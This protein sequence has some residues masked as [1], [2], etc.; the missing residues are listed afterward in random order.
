MDQQCTNSPVLIA[1]ASCAVMMLL[2]VLIISYHISNTRTSKSKKFPPMAPGGL[3]ETINI[4][5]SNNCPWWLL[6][7]AK[8]LDSSIFRMNLYLPRIPMVLQVGDPS[9]AKEIMI[10]PLT[11][12]PSTYSVFDSV[13]MGKASIF[14]SNGKYWHDRRKG[15][16]PAFSSR[17]VKRM[18]AVALKKVD[19]WI[20]T[21][22]TKMVE[23]GQ[24]FDVGKEMIGITLDSIIQ[25]AFEYTM[26][27]DEKILYFHELDLCLKEFMEK[28]AI[29]PFR[30]LVGLL[31]AD[32]RRAFVAG[33]MVSSLSLKMIQSYHGLETRTKG[34]II[35]CI[36]N[37]QSYENNLERAAD[38][39]T[40][41]IAGHDTIAYSLAWILKELA[42]NP[43][44]QRR[45]RD[46][47][48][49]MDPK[50]WNHC[51]HLHKIVKEGIRLFPV[52]AG[53]VVRVLGRD[54]ETKEGYLLPKRAM[55]IFPVMN[56]SR[57]PTVFENADCFSPSR[58]DNPT[59]AMNDAY[60]PFALG[61]QN[62]IGQS[63]A[64]EQL[65]CIVPRIIAEFDLSVKDEGTAEYFMTLK[66]SK[67]MLWAT[68]AE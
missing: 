4:L 38:I 59:K 50:E 6:Q 44:E 11:T 65:H 62:C 66:P 34:T 1:S 28:S 3:I 37:N 32:R 43:N 5:S 55:A 30:Q 47:L 57:D 68:K 13:T 20:Q 8:D 29:N 61:K 41:L 54:F 26:T 22:L 52:S 16:A 7:T 36:M 46:S 31:I 58:W 63:L 2:I 21:T 27:E 33:K 17:H 12:R 19:E 48:R 9:I 51:E 56:M 60:M 35:D 10:D 64:N 14:T 42:K 15:M 40:L 53:G 25:T 45:L 18:N 39:T 24:A 67:T 23:E 49:S